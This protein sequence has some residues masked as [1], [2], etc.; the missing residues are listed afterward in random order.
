MEAFTLRQFAKQYL[1]HAKA[2]LKP[3]SYERAEDTLD[4]RVLPVLGG[5]V[6]NRV[7]PGDIQRYVDKRIRD[8]AA[9]ATGLREMI[10]LSALFRE[11]RKAELVDRN[12]VSLVTK[13]KVNNTIVRYLSFQEETKL[14]SL[15]SEPLKSA[16]LI[17]IHT[18]MR[19]GE[20]TALKWENVKLGE[21][22]IFVRNTKSGRDRALPMN[23]KVFQILSAMPRH[24]SSPFVFVSDTGTRYDRF[25]NTPWRKALKDS[26]ILNFRWHDL[27]H[28]CAS[29]MAQA[30]VPITAVKEILGHSSIQVTMRYAHLAPA[31]L[32]DAVASLERGFPVPGTT[33]GTTQGEA[34]SKKA[35]G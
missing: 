33:H 24:F 25:N 29:R 16:I 32:R 12:P 9:P 18:G 3:S 1:E 19:E 28:T 17:S 13:P 4:K 21:R 31:N 10:V 2:Q 23:E 5:L 22:L 8:G 30:G 11:A 26:G 35:A 27:R 6:L 34:S 15:C 7:T 20:L 14:L